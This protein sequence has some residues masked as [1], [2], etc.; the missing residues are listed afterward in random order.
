MIVSWKPAGRVC[1]DAGETTG[2]LHTIAATTANEA[3]RAKG[4]D[5]M[6]APFRR[7]SGPRTRD[8][9]PHVVQVRSVGS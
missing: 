4:C 7:D 9:A 1:A 6:D 8:L 3:R 2:V 5:G